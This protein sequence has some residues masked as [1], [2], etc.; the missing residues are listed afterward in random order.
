MVTEP[1]TQPRQGSIQR[2]LHPRRPS[3]DACGASSSWSLRSL[4]RRLRPEQPCLMLP[5]ARRLTQQRA[6]PAQMPA[7]Q[8]Q[9]RTAR[10]TRRLVYASSSSSPSLRCSPYWLRFPVLVLTANAVPRAFCGIHKFSRSFL[11]SL[12]GQL[13]QSVHIITALRRDF[14]TSVSL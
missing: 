11:A 14:T 7:R 13:N 8:E 1:G 4:P 10:Q 5:Q 3:C 2:Q 12:R 6:L 9:R